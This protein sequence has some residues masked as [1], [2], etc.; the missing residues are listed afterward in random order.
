M[1]VNHKMQATSFGTYDTKPLF[2]LAGSDND[3]FPA[4]VSIGMFVVDMLFI[5]FTVN[6][7]H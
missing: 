7:N 5:L 4:Q 1:K 3:K 2:F 6:V